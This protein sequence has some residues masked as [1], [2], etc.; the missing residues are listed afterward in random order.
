M[1]GANRKFSEN[2]DNYLCGVKTHVVSDGTLTFGIKS[3]VH[4]IHTSNWCCFDN[5][6]VYRLDDATA[7]SS[8]IQDEA[9]TKQIC[10]I[11]GRR[12]D[13]LHRG[14]NIIVSEDGKVK[15]IMY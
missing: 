6:R 11:D 1:A 15:K 13:S 9:T 2:P 10:S 14:I 4:T 7:I 8:P 3:D 12:M 5:F